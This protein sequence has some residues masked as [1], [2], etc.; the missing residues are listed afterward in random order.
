MLRTETIALNLGPQHP[1]THGVFRLRLQL[2]GESVVGLEPVMG[3]LHRGIEKLCEQGTYVQVV[4]L[5]DRLDYVCSM[6]N[7][8]AYAVAVEKLL[9]LEVPERAEY[10][11]VI[12]AELTRLINHMMAVG[13]LWNELG[14]YFTPVMYCFRAREHI[15]DLFEMTC[16]SRMATFL[17][18]NEVFL[19]RAVDVGVLPADVAINASITGPMLRASGVAYDIRKV[20]RYSV[21]DHFDFD[22]PTCS[23]GDVYDRYL[24]HIKEMWQSVRIIEQA[25]E[26]FPEGEVMN[27]QAAKALRRPPKGEAYGRI[28]CP[29]GEL[30]FYVV[31]DGSANPYRVRIRPPSQINLSALKEMCEGHKIQ[32]IVIVLGSINLTMADLDR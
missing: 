29:K 17:N 27:D 12:M 7:N 14:A 23:N 8:Q 18:E 25:L 11:R 16:G 28:E 30:S 4:P 20:D 3:Y 13:F 22:V 1:S 2:D 5:T 15:L 19:A 31:S 6:T 32:D 21:Y 24:Q 10:I 9:G 26:G